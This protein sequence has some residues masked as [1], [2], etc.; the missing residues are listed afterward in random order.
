MRNGFFLSITALAAAAVSGQVNAQSPNFVTPSSGDVRFGFDR[1]G[2][3]TTYAEWFQFERTGGGGSPGNVPD[4]S[5]QASLNAAPGAAVVDGNTTSV[6]GGGTIINGTDFS[7]SIP[8]LGLGPDRPTVVALQVDFSSNIDDSIFAPNERDAF[9]VPLAVIPAAD[10]SLDN[11]TPQF[12]PASPVL[13]SGVLTD[14]APTEVLEL[15]RFYDL[16]GRGGSVPTLF[17]TSLV[18]F[19][20]PSNESGYTVGF[21]VAAGT[22]LRSVAIDVST[23]PEPSGVALFLLAMGAGGSCRRRLQ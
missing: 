6:T 13:S 17:T 14:V 9:G 4:D 10:P 3:N 15:A 5:P 11:A 16:A 12:D 2:L 18:L 23:V 1:G 20:L 19:E 21:E 22:G 7:V 8:S